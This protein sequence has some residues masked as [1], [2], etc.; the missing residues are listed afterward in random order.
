M[1]RHGYYGL[2]ALLAILEEERR[3]EI[4]R[5]YTATMLNSLGR[6]W[7]GKHWKFPAYTELAHPQEVKQD[8]RSGS[9]IIEALKKRLGG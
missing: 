8:N 5:D 2:D 1:A 9:E 6:V 7:G 3:Q 4:W